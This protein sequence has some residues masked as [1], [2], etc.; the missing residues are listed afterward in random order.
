MLYFKAVTII[1]LVNTPVF[2]NL[3]FHM[4]SET[5]D[6]TSCCAA[7]VDC[8]V[9]TSAPGPDIALM[10]LSS[11]HQLTCNSPFVDVF[12]EPFGLPS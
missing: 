4:A 1:V 10:L 12:A 8:G 9:S 3:M 6:N 2:P 7:P 5:C 11:W